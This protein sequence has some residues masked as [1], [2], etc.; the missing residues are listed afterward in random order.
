M[1]PSAIFKTTIM[2]LCMAMACGSCIVHKDH[3]PRPPH[4]KKH[5]P[6]KK[7]KGPKHHPPHVSVDYDNT[8]NTYYAWNV[9]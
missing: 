7:P 2:A 9:E 4:H 6:P 5:K 8:G 3:P 1:R